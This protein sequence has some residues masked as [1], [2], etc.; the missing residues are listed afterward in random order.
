V[1]QI[2]LPFLRGQGFGLSV[3]VRSAGGEAGVEGSPGTYGWSGAYNTYFRIDPQE[4]IVLAI[5][6]QQSPANDLESTYG[7][8]NLV[9]QAVTD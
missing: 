9:M 7:F 8:Q 3:A 4:K 2:P 6:Q 5:F 1:Q